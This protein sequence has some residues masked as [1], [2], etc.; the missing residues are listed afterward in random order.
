MEQS[1][2]CW[3]SHEQWYDSRQSEEIYLFSKALRLVLGP[4][5]PP[6]D[7]DISLLGAKAAAA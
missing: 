4:T 3:M 5:L 1:A 6:V 2:T 7:T